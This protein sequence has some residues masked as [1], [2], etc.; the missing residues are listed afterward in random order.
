MPHLLYLICEYL[1]HIFLLLV[2]LLLLLLLLLRWDGGMV[3]VRMRLLKDIFQDFI[4]TILCFTDASR[5]K[6]QIT[7]H[8][9][10]VTPSPLAPS[11]H[12]TSQ[13]L[14]P[15]STARNPYARSSNSSKTATESQ[16]SSNSNTELQTVVLGLLPFIDPPCLPPL[17]NGTILWY[18]AHYF[19]HV[20]ELVP[21]WGS[22]EYL[23]T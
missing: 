4:L 12:A 22:G 20:D 11:N 2:V 23:D 19:Y 1:G 13:S 9:F 6:L 5:R 8:K 7:Q 18:V 16:P 17:K 14:R 10:K 3:L 21:L 15:G